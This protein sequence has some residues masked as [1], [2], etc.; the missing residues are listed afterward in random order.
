[1]CFEF[2]LVDSQRELT[3]IRSE[4]KGGGEKFQSDLRLPIARPRRTTRRRC[5]GK[6][7][8]MGVFAG[9]RYPRWANGAGH[10]RCGI[11]MA[12]FSFPPAEEG[13]SADLQV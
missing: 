11:F 8:K 9:G 1:M 12:F 2:P 6:R 13:P 4:V 10:N 5:C 7:G 3:A